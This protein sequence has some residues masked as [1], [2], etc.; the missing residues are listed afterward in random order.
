MLKIKI[1]QKL[2]LGFLA[3]ICFNL[4]LIRIDLLEIKGSF[5]IWLGGLKHEVQ[6]ALQ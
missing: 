5:W 4:K 1:L 3:G 6:H 2:V